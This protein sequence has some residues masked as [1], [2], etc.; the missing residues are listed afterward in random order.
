MAR[1]ALQF[2]DAG[3]NRYPTDRANTGAVTRERATTALAEVVEE[4]Q[5]AFG[6]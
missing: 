5:G 1:F 3:T 4:F 2:V 6:L